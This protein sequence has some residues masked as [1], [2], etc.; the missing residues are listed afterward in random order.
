M[1]FLWLALVFLQVL[2]FQ[3]FVLQ[4]FN[5][6]FNIN[7]IYFFKGTGLYDN[8]KKFN[9]TNPEDI[10]CINFFE[11][12]PKPFYQLARELFKEDVKV[13]FLYL[14]FFF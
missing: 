11:K 8:L 4:V 10:F 1:L 5:L 12:N 2:E 3:I 6:N 9:L 7:F 14:K 13:C